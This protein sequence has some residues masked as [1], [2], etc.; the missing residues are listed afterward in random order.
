MLGGELWAN[1]QKVAG[2]QLAIQVAALAGLKPGRRNIPI[3]ARCRALELIKVDAAMVQ[4]CPLCSPDR[5][6]I[7]IAAR[8]EDLAALL[9]GMHKDHVA[10]ALQLHSEYGVA[11]Q[12]LAYSANGTV[13][14][15]TL[16]V[17]VAAE[18]NNDTR[19]RNNTQV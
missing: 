4:I 1:R 9:H 11:T 7:P 14:E 5:R 2:S 19:L 15:T 18:P 12:R 8:Q 16:F 3:S 17:K 6:G 13:H 10:R